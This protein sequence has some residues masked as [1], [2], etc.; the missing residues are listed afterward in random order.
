MSDKNEFSEKV[1]EIVKQIPIGKV[2]TYGII[3]QY[4]GARKS[5]RTVGYILNSC[6]GNNTYPYHR[7]INRLG[8]LTGKHH[9][10][11]PT[12][13]KEMLVSEGIQ[14]IGD[15]VDLKRHLWHPEDIL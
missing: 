8:E 13:M 3:A 12:A 6:K 10:P 14:F 7:V 1:L 5:A 11:S 4:A 2:C 15:A 9:F